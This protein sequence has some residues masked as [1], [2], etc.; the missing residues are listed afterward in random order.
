MPGH[1]ARCG[2]ETG[3]GVHGGTKPVRGE[4]SEPS[5]RIFEQGTRKGLLAP[6]AQVY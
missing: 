1:L 4:T 5:S 3:R 2:W 6:I